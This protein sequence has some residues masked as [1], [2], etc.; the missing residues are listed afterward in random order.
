[1]ASVLPPP[2]PQSTRDRLLQAAIQVFSEAGYV[3]AT[4]RAIAQQAGVSEVTLFR[5]FQR[6]EQLLQAVAQHIAH[7][8]MESFPHQ[9]FCSAHPATDLLR[10]AH[11]YNQ[12][13]E[14]N[15]ALFRM[16]IGEAHRHPQEAVEV[17][18]QSFLPLRASLIT[19]LQTCIALEPGPTPEHL[20]MVVDQLTA[21][22]LAGMIRRHTGSIE[23]PYG[24]EAYVEACIN[25]VLTGLGLP[26]VD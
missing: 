7:L 22:L 26:L 25:L 12:M 16:F 19:Y 18:Q 10:Y 17:L 5:H 8:V 21:M 9:P 13:L 2:A 20:T 1:M 14:E 24:Q 6:K 11:L 15:Q 4:T 3:G 23:R